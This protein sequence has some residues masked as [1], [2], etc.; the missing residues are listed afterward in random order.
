MIKLK[1]AVSAGVLSLGLVV[2]VAG[3]A[4]AT[5]GSIGTTGP[6]SDN[7]VVN[8]S[9]TDIDVDND[10]D[11]RLSNTNDQY[12]TSGPAGV[13]KNTTGGHATTGHSDNN[14]SVNA[15]VEIDNSSSTEAALDG[16]DLGSNGGT[17]SIH[18]TGPNSDNIVTYES[19]VNIDVDNDNDIRIQNN[20]VQMAESGS[21]DV[22]YNTT[23]GNA[24]SGNVSN[25]SSTNFTVRVTN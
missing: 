14:S 10:N 4:G 22:S 23:G 11:I 25:T 9:R 12:A 19:R 21:A 7:E 16:V 3:F 13:K 6:Y 18:N 20:S 1:K 8:D 24:T 2:G 17:G 5:S 15:M